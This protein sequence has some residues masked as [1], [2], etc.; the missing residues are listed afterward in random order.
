MLGSQRMPVQGLAVGGVEVRRSRHCAVA[1]TVLVLSGLLAGCGSSSHQGAPSNSDSHERATTSVPV[2]ADHDSAAATSDDSAAHDTADS[3]TPAGGDSTIPDDAGSGAAGSAP[4]EP[5][6]AS[7]EGVEQALRTFI[8]FV[9][10]VKHGDQAC[11]DRLVSD[12]FVSRLS[13]SLNDK[14]DPRWISFHPPG[15]GGDMPSL[16]ERFVDLK[17]PV[18]PSTVSDEPYT[19]PIIVAAG[20]SPP[21]DA[22]PDQPGGLT[23]SCPFGTGH[24]SVDLV[25]V[26]G[27]YE[28]D[29][30]TM[31]Y[32]SK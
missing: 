28:V 27:V 25:V 14:D 6:S 32:F 11:A 29:D 1:V 22:A 24:L 21:V 2:H 7:N 13:V 10:A 5:A 26:N 4:C 31:S 23:L 30:L 8:P 16:E 20:E 18:D 15:I 9:E 19:R 3:G 12:W 17:L